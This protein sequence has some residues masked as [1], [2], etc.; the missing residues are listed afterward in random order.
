[1]VHRRLARELPEQILE[2][3]F[4]AAFACF[5][6]KGFERTTMDEIAARA[7]VARAT[8][9]YYFGGK[10]DLL[11]YLLERGFDMLEAAMAEIAGRH[12]SA[13]ERLEAAVERIVEMI[14]EYRDVAV[15]VMLQL[16]RLHE[17]LSA[18]LH[19]EHIAAL[20]TLLQEGARDG[21]IRE[22]DPDT[23]AP[24]IFGA[25]LWSVLSH[26]ELTGSVPVER[27]KRQVGMLVMEG[28]GV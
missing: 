23:L 24:A 20:R 17:Q 27:V 2:K 3:L 10:E 11:L 12:G 28:L 16:G 14:A 26:Y 9:Y 15:V 25:A 8:L 4:P 7:G 1:M 21:S 5:C 13:R 22:A 6:E 18:R 19:T